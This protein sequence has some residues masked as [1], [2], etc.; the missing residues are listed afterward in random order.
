M[1]D[2]DIITARKR[3][4]KLNAEEIAQAIVDEIREDPA[5]NRGPATI[6]AQLK[7]KTIHLPRCVSKSN[8]T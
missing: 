3:N 8:M 4:I 7:K 2:L 1:K 5:G 6:Q